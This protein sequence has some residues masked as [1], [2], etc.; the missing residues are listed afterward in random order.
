MRQGQQSRCRL[1]DGYKRRWLAS[2]HCASLEKEV[3]QGGV[4]PEHG[5][6]YHARRCVSLRAQG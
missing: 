2:P 6:C 4:A 1:V 5:H 3:V